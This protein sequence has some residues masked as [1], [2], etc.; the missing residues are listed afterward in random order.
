MSRK[1]SPAIIGAFVVGG[2]ALLVLGV[3]VMAGSRIFRQTKPVVAYFGQSVN[4]LSVGAPVKFFGIEVGTVRDISI[5]LSSLEKGPD[6]VRIPVVLELD[7]KRLSAEG[8][9]VDLNDPRILPTLVA[10]G[11][12]AELAMESPVTGLRYVSLTI[13]PGTPAEMVA[14]PSLAYPEIPTLPSKDEQILDKA[15]QFFA[16]LERADV[17]GLVQS[18]RATSDGARAIVTSPDLLRSVRR[19]DELTAHLDAAVVEVRR[20]ASELG[21]NGSVG[22]SLAASSKSV[23]TITS[24]GA[25]AT[26]SMRR[27][28]APDGIFLGDLDA[29]LT[30]LHNAARSFRRVAD[31]V[32]RDPGAVLRGGRQ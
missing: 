27:L 18:I 29:T 12:R 5:G 13:Q 7:Q 21:P 14:P 10:K 22:R 16:G 28:L 25:Q 23:E 32:G 17:A 30:D 9:R 31:Q 4:G 2:L 26:A 15:M 6:R 8:A 19:L 11:L 1:A 24:E 3:V 20:T